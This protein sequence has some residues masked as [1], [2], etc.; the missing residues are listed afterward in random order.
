MGEVSQNL[1]DRR[2]ASDLSED[3]K[4]I[5]FIGPKFSGKTSL[6]RR[7]SA[8]PLSFCEKATIGVD[9]VPVGLW[10][11]DGTTARYMMWDVSGEERFC[12]LS[13]LYYRGAAGALVVFD[14]S[15]PG[16]L[17]ETEDW[18][19][20]LRQ[21]CGP[22][23]PVVLVGNKS[24]LMGHNDPQAVRPEALKAFCERLGVPVFACVSARTGHNVHMVFGLLCNR[25]DKHSRSNGESLPPV[26][27]LL[28][29]RVV[30]P[31]RGPR[32]RGRRG[33]AHRTWSCALL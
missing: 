14:L 9:M 28:P 15:R 21:R 18:I 33:G 25:V 27:R 20:D 29:E 8:L 4:K 1:P 2:C 19:A 31:G 7:I 12:S 23:I 32:Q 3:S 24:D 13:Q 11:S 17:T 16:T 5:L 26:V 10:R 22:D 6:I 30:S